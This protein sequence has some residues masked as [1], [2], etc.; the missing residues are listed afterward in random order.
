MLLEGPWEAWGAP[1]LGP[2]KRIGPASLLCTRCL[3]G[4]I[5]ALGPQCSTV[6]ISHSSLWFLWGFFFNILSEPLSREALKSFVVLLSGPGNSRGKTAYHIVTGRQRSITD[7]NYRLSRGSPPQ[8][9]G[10]MTV[11]SA[12]AMLT[13]ATARDSMER[14]GKELLQDGCNVKYIIQCSAN[15]W[16]SKICNFFYLIHKLTWP[17][18]SK[19]FS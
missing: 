1:A 9:D 11:L 17:Y 7:E 10:T 18:F 4:Q 8:R 19:L 2:L 12:L 15:S 14:K 3:G 13:L 6:N 16:C 5:W